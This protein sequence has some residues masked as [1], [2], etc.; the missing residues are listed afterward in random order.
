M[1]ILYWICLIWTI[2]GTIYGMVDMVL[3]IKSDL[4]ENKESESEKVRTYL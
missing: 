3:T 4:K 2:V 1:E